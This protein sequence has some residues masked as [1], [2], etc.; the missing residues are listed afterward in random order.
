MYN[1][2][3]AHDHMEVAMEVATTS[4]NSGVTIRFG[5]YYIVVVDRSCRI[6]YFVVIEVTHIMVM[7]FKLSCVHLITY[8][9]QASISLVD[10]LNSL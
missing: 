1:I 5:C 4:D 10:S 8:F 7:T 6:A 9:G 3:H 2:R